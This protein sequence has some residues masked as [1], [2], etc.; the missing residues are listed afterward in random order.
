MRYL[1]WSVIALAMGAS[2]LAEDEYVPLVLGTEW[3]MAGKVEAP[4]G[5]VSETVFHRRLEGTVDR[6]GVS[7]FRLRT[8]T[9]GLPKNYDSTKLVRKDDKAFYSIEDMEK[10]I[11]EQMELTLPLKIGATWQRKATAGMMTVTVVGLESISV[12]G[13]TYENCFHLRSVMADAKFTED[14]WEAPGVGR[15]KS[16]TVVADGAKVSMTLTEFKPA[17]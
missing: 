3:V 17:K 10:D 7:Y 13:K 9:E 5:R 2:A 16:E 4:T 1:L 14:F 11:P 15:V 8:W 12:S 6:G